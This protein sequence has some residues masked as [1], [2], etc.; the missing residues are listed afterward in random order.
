MAD[1]SLPDTIPDNKEL[2]R[3]LNRAKVE[4]QLRALTAVLGMPEP[5]S[6]AIEGMEKTG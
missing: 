1:K 4:F 5:Q 3:E 6:L 2:L